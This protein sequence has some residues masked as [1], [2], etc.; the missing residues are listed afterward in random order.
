VR[1]P[2]NTK[3]FRGQLDAG[4]YAGVF[5]LLVIFLLLNSSLVFTPGVRIELPEAANLP[6]PDTPIVAVAVD[7]SDQIYFDHQ[8]ITEVALRE[9]LR[10]GVARTPS[11]TLVVQG[12]KSASVGTLMRLAQMAREVGIKQ[13]HIAARPPPVSA[14]RPVLLP[15]P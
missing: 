13:A 11:L 4:P 9:Q 8:L 1:F 10:A 12:D 3:V 5:F 14:A 6:G 2:R 7:N 15:A